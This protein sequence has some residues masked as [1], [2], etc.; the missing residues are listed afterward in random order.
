M[1][2]VERNVEIL[3]ISNEGERGGEMN[4]PVEEFLFS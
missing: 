3:T 1:K 4:L 2:K